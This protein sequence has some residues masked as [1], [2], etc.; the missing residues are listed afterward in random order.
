[1]ADMKDIFSGSGNQTTAS[2]AYLLLMANVLGLA[3]FIDGKKGV[4]SFSK[5]SG[6][7]NNRTKQ[8]IEQ[9]STIGEKSIVS[10]IADQNEPTTEDNTKESSEKNH[11]MFNQNQQT[12]EQSNEEIP[13]FRD[14]IIDFKEAVALR[15]QE[16]KQPLKPLIWNFPKK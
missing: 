3:I 10:E 8:T 15:T 7:K 14:N 16:T 11:V 9:V 6:Y 4:H 2:M 1:M 12:V 13:K 5:E